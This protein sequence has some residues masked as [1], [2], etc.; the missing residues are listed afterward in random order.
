[1]I[2]S[3]NVG[4]FRG[5]VDAMCKMLNIDYFP[6][7]NGDAEHF[8]WD[9]HELLKHCVCKFGATTQKNMKTFLRNTL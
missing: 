1:M 4:A 6:W 5:I 7:G 3:K 9:I 2:Q 8:N